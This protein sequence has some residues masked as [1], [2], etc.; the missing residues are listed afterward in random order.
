MLPN[1]D[2]NKNTIGFRLKQIH[3]AMEKS[4][5]S[6]LKPYGLTLSQ[7]N[8]LLFLDSYQ[9]EEPVTIRDIELFFGLQH[10][11]IT[12]IVKRL[13]EKKL[14]VTERG[15]A[16]KRCTIVKIAPKAEI[17][18]NAMEKHRKLMDSLL[19]HTMTEVEQKQLAILLDKVLNNLST[20]PADLNF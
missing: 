16:D 5:N 10:P 19:V 12:G 2:S 9:G 1:I 15:T 20:I 3:D 14:V 13:E 11:T 4:V 6:Y 7:I 8:V 17:I 18:Q